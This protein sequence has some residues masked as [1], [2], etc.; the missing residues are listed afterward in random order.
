MCKGT[1]FDD[2]LIPAGKLYPAI[3]I[4]ATLRGYTVTARFG[5]SAAEEGGSENHLQVARSPAEDRSRRHGT[6]GGGRKHSRPLSNMGVVVDE[7]GGDGEDDTDS[8]FSW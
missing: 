4:D 2:G 7:E 8:S 5:G 3:S 6:P 1:A